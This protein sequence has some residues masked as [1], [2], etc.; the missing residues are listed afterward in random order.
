MF[1]E[2]PQI[3]SYPISK[4]AKRAP[5]IPSIAKR[6]LKYPLRCTQDT[7]L[8]DPRLFCSLDPEEEKS[9]S[10]DFDGKVF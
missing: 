9:A 2:N 10:S 7:D 4:I 1:R 5:E 6:A 8:R 3:L